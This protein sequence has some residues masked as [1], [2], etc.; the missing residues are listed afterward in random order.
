MASRADLPRR[1]SRLGLTEENRRWCQ[2]LSG[3]AARPHRGVAGQ[4]ERL[5]SS[6]EALAASSRRRT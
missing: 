2:E 4:I 5:Q 1:A 6:V 3:G